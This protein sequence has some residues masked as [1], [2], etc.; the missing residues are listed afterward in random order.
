MTEE[1]KRPVET[2]DQTDD[3][4]RVIHGGRNLMILGLAATIIAVITTAI[5]LIVYRVTGDIYLDRSRPGYISED[6]KNEEKYDIKEN[7]SADGDITK[8][9]VDEYL[10][11]LDSIR[12]RIDSLSNAFD[13]DPLNDDALSIYPRDQEPDEEPQ[14]EPEE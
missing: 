6:E 9:T 8:N 3:T 1:P 2:P 11:Q 7:F 4:P 10:N 13:G 12:G 5:S 14:T